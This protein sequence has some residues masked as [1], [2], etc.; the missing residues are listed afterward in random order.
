MEEDEKP[1]KQF[2][3]V[4]VFVGVGVLLVILIIGCIVFFLMKGG[5]DNFSSITISTKDIV[6]GTY[7]ILDE[8]TTMKFNVNE[9]EHQMKIDLLNENSVNIT[10]SSEII[11]EII[12]VGETKRFDLDNDTIFD[13]GVVL[14][15]ITEGKVNFFVKKISE[16]CVENWNC[17]EWTECDEGNQIRVCNEVNK[18]GASEEKPVETQVC[19]VIPPC[20]ELG[21][22]ICDT[23]TETCA[24]NITANSSDEGCC[25]GECKIKSLEVINCGEDIDCLISASES[26]NPSNLTYSSTLTN[27]TWTQTANSYYKIRGLEDDKC[28]LY[29]EI[30]GNE[31]SFTDAG[32]Q[33]LISEGKTE[34][35]IDVLEEEISN[36]IKGETGMCRFSVY[37]LKERLTELKEGNTFITTGELESYECSG[38]AVW[39]N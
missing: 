22:V 18:C 39:I 3:K 30:L 11:S 28:K 2:P 25:L 21:G 29:K 6:N 16:Q 34:E 9:E 20:A 13:L 7:V 37:N 19:V 23:T 31:G 33:S 15:N 35:E 36:S 8:N 14:H 12:N 5:T 26:C 17:S 27:S 24:G 1:K 10:I 38:Y 4:L 32:K